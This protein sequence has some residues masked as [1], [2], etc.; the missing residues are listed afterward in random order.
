MLE[1]RIQHLTEMP[2]S[3]WNK[4]SNY[5]NMDICFSN[6][7]T[8]TNTQQRKLGMPVCRTTK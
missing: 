8:N 1:Y 4:I 2:K 7:A 6:N 3:C 5:T